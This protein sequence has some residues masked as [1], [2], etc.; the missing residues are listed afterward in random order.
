MSNI[1]KLLVGA[2]GLAAV[3][4]VASPAMAQGYPYGYGNQGQS[5]GSGIVGA[6]INSVTG[7]GYG[8]Y[9]QGN[10]GYGQVN[11]RTAVSQCAAA[12]EQRLNGGYG[13]S[14]Y[15]NQGYGNNGYQSGYG[16]ARVV[17]ITNVERRSNG[18]LRVTGLASSGQAYGGYGNQGYGNQGY[19]N[20]G[21]GNQGYQGGYGAAGQADLSFTCKVDYSGR[22]TS[23]N[24]NRQTAYGRGY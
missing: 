2:A 21:Y 22:V 17:G 20:Q 1:S 14:S 7:G 3:V 11:E 5:T 18:K 6:I 13:Q 9:P 15:G 19:G 24:F 16:Q 10:Y 8:R 12:A 4:G 23:L